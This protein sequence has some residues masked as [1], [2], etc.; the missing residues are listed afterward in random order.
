MQHLFNIIKLLPKKLKICIYFFIPINIV[1]AFTELMSL[2]SIT[3]IIINIL[4]LEGNNNNNFYIFFFKLTETINFKNINL[5]VFIF[6][7]FFIFFSWIFKII[8]LRLSLHV[9]NYISS[10]LQILI[11]KKYI[12]Q[13]FDNFVVEKHSEVLSKLTLITYRASFY[14]ESFFYLVS[15]IIISFFILIFLSLINPILTIS[16]VVLLILFFLFVYLLK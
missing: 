2:A 7:I 14:L 3:T 12:S 4:D 5:F 16:I 10:N 9:T 1:L 11:F 15:S 6:F 8:N 13:S